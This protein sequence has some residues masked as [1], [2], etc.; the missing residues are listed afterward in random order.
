VG[1]SGPRRLP[2]PAVRRQANEETESWLRRFRAELA[3]R[4]ERGTLVAAR[5]EPI[6]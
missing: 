2:A 6:A 4:G 3:A 1:A 5:S